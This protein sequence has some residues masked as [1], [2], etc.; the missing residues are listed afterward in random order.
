MREG[1]RE[2][3]RDGITCR[4]NVSF[5]LCRCLYLR[6]CARSRWEEK[7]GWR[8]MFENIPTVQLNHRALAYSTGNCMR[9]YKCVYA[10]STGQFVR[11]CLCE[12]VDV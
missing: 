9:V 5:F 10:Y 6:L 12:C 1:V 8:N 11:V 2:S 3:S 4:R 7:L